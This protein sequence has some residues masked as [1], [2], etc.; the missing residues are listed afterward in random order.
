V[1]EGILVERLEIFVVWKYICIVVI[2]I[3]FKIAKGQSDTLNVGIADAVGTAN[4]E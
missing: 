3:A 1:Y 4:L 2:V